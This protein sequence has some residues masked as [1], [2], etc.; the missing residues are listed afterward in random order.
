VLQVSSSG[1]FANL[2]RADASE[3]NKRISNEALLVHIKAIHA[4]VKGEYGW[5]K[6]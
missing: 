3:P 6:I 4:Q 2:R 5:P 1:Y